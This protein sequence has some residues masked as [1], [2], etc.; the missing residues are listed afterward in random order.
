[1]IH[2]ELAVLQIAHQPLRASRDMPDMKSR[3]VEAVGRCPKLFRGQPLREL[4][5]VLARLLKGAEKGSDQGMNPGN[6]AAQPG[7]RNHIDIVP[8]LK[9][10]TRSAR[11][12]S[13]EAARRAGTLLEGKATT[14]STAATAANVARSAAFTPNKRLL[15][16]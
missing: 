7:L 8:T 5:Q 15:R 9:P 12:G 6:R 11:L 13:V 3:R 2:S 4:R 1:M 10:Y 14:V 16:S